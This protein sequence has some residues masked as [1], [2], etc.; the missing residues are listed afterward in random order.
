MLRSSLP[1]TSLGS[2]PA[3]LPS[4]HPRS[5][6]R[7]YTSR[8]SNTRELNTRE[9]DLPSSGSVL[10]ER[11]ASTRP[12]PRGERAGDGRKDPGASAHAHALGIPHSA[13]LPSSSA[14]ASNAPSGD[15]TALLP[16]PSDP[17]SPQSA[18]Q[19]T[20]HNPRFTALS[21]KEREG[22]REKERARERDREREG[23]SLREKESE[24]AAATD[25]VS[26]RSDKA[27]QRPALAP[28]S[29]ALQRSG[30]A[31]VG[32]T[33]VADTSAHGPLHL[34]S[35]RTP[36][37]ANANGGLATRVP[38]GRLFHPDSTLP[39]NPELSSASAYTLDT[40]ARLRS[41]PPTHATTPTHSQTLA[42]GVGDKVPYPVLNASGGFLPGSATNDP[43]ALALPPA[44]LAPVP[45]LTPSNAGPAA[46]A[47]AARERAP[48]FE[49]LRASAESNAAGPQTTAPSQPL[50]TSLNTSRQP[51]LPFSALSF[52][53]L[54]T[55]HLSAPGQSLSGGGVSESLG[56]LAGQVGAHSDT[57]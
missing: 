39:P 21:E 47:A 48:Q 51:P 38:P 42:G 27:A 16:R 40:S 19:P 7:E 20:L 5:P 31:N 9:R 17:P 22:E 25:I 15:G 52:P 1:N 28:S 18:F 2:A 50:N 35:A 53:P 54:L 11:A 6:G 12:I 3:P 44:V 8:A 57:L 24:R 13:N 56:L 43:L 14:A 41:A 46:S 30:T 26:A 34:P 10:E 55:P 36:S 37:N 23:E 4:T 45:V 49:P 29:D 33:R 32:I